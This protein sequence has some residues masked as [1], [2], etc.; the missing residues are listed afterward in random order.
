MGSGFDSDCE[1]FTL[2]MI[3]AQAARDKQL[4]IALENF[5]HHG[6]PEAQIIAFPRLVCRIIWK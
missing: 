2:E 1:L 4:D 6:T 3:A 5:F